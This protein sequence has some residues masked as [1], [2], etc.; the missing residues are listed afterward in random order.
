MT[1]FF[2]GDPS[3]SHFTVGI[4]ED[5]KEYRRLMDEC[6]AEYQKRGR[7]S[8]WQ[9]LCQ[10]RDEAYKAAKRDYETRK[11]RLKEIGFK[12]PYF[13]FRDKDEE[14][15]TSAK[16]QA[17]AFAKEWSAKAGFTL[18]VNEGCFL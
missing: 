2:G 15:K 12:T 14:G 17:E 10:R 6:G 8:R 4:H 5:R 7:T 3:M 13:Q 18:D 11:Q 9:E 1:S 16:A